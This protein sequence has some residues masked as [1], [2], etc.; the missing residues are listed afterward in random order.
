MVVWLDFRF[1]AN[2]RNLKIAHDFINWTAPVER[3]PNCFDLWECCH[4][5]WSHGYAAEAGN[6]VLGPK[7]ESMG[8]LGR[9]PHS[10][11]DIILHPNTSALKAPS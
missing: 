8:I 1:L 9:L 3:V 2:L 11:C 4:I 5:L 7:S 6:A 10:R